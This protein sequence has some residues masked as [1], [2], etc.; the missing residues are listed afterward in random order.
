MAEQSSSVFAHVNC[1][2]HMACR[3]LTLLQLQVHSSRTRSWSRS[4]SDE[5]I[6]VRGGLREL[7]M[8]GMERRVV[9]LHVAYSSAQT[10]S[11]RESIEG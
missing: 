4:V 7:V 1:W 10:D 8:C 2:S 11:M 9:I 6:H 5:E 3:T